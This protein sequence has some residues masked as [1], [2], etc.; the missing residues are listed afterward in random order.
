MSRRRA[1]GDPGDGL[2][3]EPTDGRTGL[4]VGPFWTIDEG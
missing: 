2:G 3:E 1:L 4:A